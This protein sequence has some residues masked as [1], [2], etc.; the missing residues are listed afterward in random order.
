M[1][2]VQRLQVALRW[3]RAC[4]A[5]LVAVICSP[6][7]VLPAAAAAPGLSLIGRVDKDSAPVGEVVSYDFAVAN[8]GNAAEGDVIVTDAVPPGLQYVA[9]SAT[10]A[11]PCSAAYDADRAIV[12]WR[13][14]SLP[15]G[16]EARL[17][18]SARIR[19]LT[20][21]PDGSL[22]GTVILTAAVGSSAQTPAAASNE[23]RIVV[24]AV[25]GSKIVRRSSPARLPRA[26]PD[27]Q[28]TQPGMRCSGWGLRNLPAVSVERGPAGARRAR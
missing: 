25:L 27:R 5:L 22:P 6:L 19:A 14:G 1:V 9:G 12:T 13:L 20:T 2:R 21:N 18:F 23:V 15:A 16:P 17:S 26:R 24:V 28:E 7:A 11:P 4:A 10:C 3:R 8:T